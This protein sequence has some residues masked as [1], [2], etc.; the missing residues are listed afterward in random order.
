M[1]VQKRGWDYLQVPDPV[2]WGTE[3]LR[4]RLRHGLVLVVH[5]VEKESGKPVQDFAVRMQLAAGAMVPLYVGDLAPREAGHHEDG[6]VAMPACWRSPY[7]LVVEPESKALWRS[8]LQKIDLKDPGPVHVTVAVPAA[9]T[10]TLRLVTASGAA[11]ADCRVELAEPLG[12]PVTAETLVLPLNQWEHYSGFKKAILA[13]AGATDRR[14]ELPLSGPAGTLL[15]LRVLGPGCVPQVVSDVRLDVGDPLVVTVAVGGTLRVVATPVDVIG[16]LDDLMEEKF[17]GGVVGEDRERKTGLLLMRSQGTRRETLPGD[18]KPPIAFNPDGRLEYAGVP[19]GTWTLIL[20]WQMGSARQ[21]CSLREVEL[22]DGATTEVALDLAALRPATLH[23]RIVLNGAPYSGQFMLRGDHGLGRNG[24]RML[25]QGLQATDAE[26]SF[27]YRG[28]AG[29]YRISLPFGTESMEVLGQPEV[30]LAAG[31][32]LEQVF[33]VVIGSLRVRFLD[34]ED[35]PVANLEG[36]RLMRG[37]RDYYAR[38]PT[39]DTD[40]RSSL[41]TC[42]AGALHV[43]VMRRR[44]AAPAAYQEYM[45]QHPEDPY[46]DQLVLDLGTITVSEGKATEVDV[47]VPP[48]YFK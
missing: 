32:V 5:A 30:R 48:A 2:R 39:S 34:A 6:S 3:D 47:R 14:G 21:S 20:C 25:V 11:V 27:T 31:D 19:P 40:G 37:P 41:S 16:A 23:G 29:T 35:K 15:A 8:A 7:M 9:A 36:T 28:R 4:L 22:I 1:I 46:M 12:E 44:Y 45:Q 43:L 33:T 38:L 24:N 42:E 26:G 13:H 18:Q 17:N 10:R